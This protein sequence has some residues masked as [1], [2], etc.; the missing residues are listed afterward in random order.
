MQ[1]EEFEHVLAAAAEVTGEEEFVVIGSQAILGSIALPPSA[2]LVSM[3]VDIYPKNAPD[4]A[5]QIDASL[6]DGSPFHSSFGYYAHGVGPMTAKAP[7]G[8]QARLVRREIP[9]RVAGKRTAVAWCLEIH[10]LLLSKCA[11]GRTRD[12]EYAREVIDAGLVD[13]QLLFARIA[14][15]PV[16][17]RER[18][19]VEK[20]LRG[21]TG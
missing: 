1:S 12:W 14:D 17:A 11:A 7:S 3:E 2:L 13:V 8:W 5:L 16:G 20:M 9:R 10:D 4:A 18:N 15:M 21:F 19:H 6:G